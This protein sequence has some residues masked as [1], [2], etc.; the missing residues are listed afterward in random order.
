MPGYRWWRYCTVIGQ[1]WAPPLVTGSWL[2]HWHSWLWLSFIQISQTN[3]WLPGRDQAVGRPG[4]PSHSLLL[5]A[6]RY[7][8][9]EIWERLSTDPCHTGSINN[10]SLLK[11]EDINNWAKINRR[12]NAWMILGNVLCWGKFKTQ[13]W[14]D[15][16][17]ISNVISILTR[18][19]RPW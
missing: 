5:A 3:K 6:A 1:L 17:F 16:I 14:L 12:S 15:T 19:K 10:E 2:V 8:I 18:V 13:V 11:S 7:E 9:M 4:L